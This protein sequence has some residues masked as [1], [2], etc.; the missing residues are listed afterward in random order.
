[1]NQVF[2]STHYSGADLI[3]KFGVNEAWK[4]VFGPIF[5]YLNSNSDG[6]SPINLWEDAKH[7]VIP[8]LLLTSMYQYRG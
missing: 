3:M 6:L 2:H 1:M 8:K 4:K 7:Q 5:I